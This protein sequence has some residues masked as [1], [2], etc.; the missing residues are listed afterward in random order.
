MDNPF[1]VVQISADVTRNGNRIVKIQRKSVIEDEFGESESSETYYRAVKE[2]TVKLKLDDEMSKAF[3]PN[4]YNIVERTHTFNDTD[5]G[6]EVVRNLKW[7]HS[8]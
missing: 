4:N 7:L 2:G 5:T 3:S 8:K 6:E 1:I